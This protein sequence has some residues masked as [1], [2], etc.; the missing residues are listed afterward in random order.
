[1]LFL[2]LFISVALLNK[3]GIEFI[4]A[5]I[6]A[7][8]IITFLISLCIPVNK[9]KTR[10]NKKLKASNISKS[11][12]ANKVNKLRSD[13]EILALPLE[14]LSW[15]EFEQLCYLFFKTKGYKTEKTKK[16]AD[17]GIDLIYYNKHHQQN[18]AVQI[19]HHIDS[20]KPVTVKE[21]RE[22]DSSKKNYKCVLA[23]FMSSTGYTK[24]ALIEAD[25]RHI[26]CHAV[27]K[28]KRWKEEEAKRRKIS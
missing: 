9:K 18:V 25:N 7:P 1:M 19:K 12:K 4:I 27:D 17:G 16:G 10:T 6:I 14:E 24:N 28:I 11:T 2:F 20:G 23:D 5:A 8:S 15:E 13:N 26:K 22:L 21:I 3:L